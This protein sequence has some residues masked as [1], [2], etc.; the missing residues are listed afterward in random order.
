MLSS[1]SVTLPRAPQVQILPQSVW[2]L[3]RLVFLLEAEPGRQQLS[4]QNDVGLSPE[5]CLAVV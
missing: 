5:M 4:P 3:G 2:A 1:P